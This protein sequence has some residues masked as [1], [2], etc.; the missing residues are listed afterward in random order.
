V[1]GEIRFLGQRSDVF[2]L[3]KAA[4]IFIYGDPPPQKWSDLKYVFWHKEDPN[5]TFTSTTIQ[6][7][8]HPLKNPA[9][10]GLTEFVGGPFLFFQPHQQIAIATVA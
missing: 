3:L 7:A 10:A 9:L 1:E 8:H 6:S 5:S 4:D 2:E